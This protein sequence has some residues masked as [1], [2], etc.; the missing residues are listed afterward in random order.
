MLY[1]AVLRLCLRLQQFR[2]SAWLV[3]GD[4]VKSVG[5]EL[6]DPW[7]HDL[8]AVAITAPYRAAPLSSAREVVLTPDGVH[9]CSGAPAAQADSAV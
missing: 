7:F 3:C 5:G 1:R 9:L 2:A 6:H 4:P 8:G